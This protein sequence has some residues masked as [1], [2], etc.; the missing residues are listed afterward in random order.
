MIRT[1]RASAAKAP[2]ASLTS[3]GRRTQRSPSAPPCQPSTESAAHTVPGRVD[4]RRRRAGRRPARPAR[5]PPRRPGHA[6]RVPQRVDRRL[7][8]EREPL[9]ARRWAR[10]GRP[11]KRVD[12]FR[13]V[14]MTRALPVGSNR[15]MAWRISGGGSAS[16]GCRRGWPRGDAA[17]GVRR[18]SMSPRRGGGGRLPTPS[19]PTTRTASAPR[20]ADQFGG[21]GEAGDRTTGEDD[22]A[23]RDERSEQLGVVGLPHRRTVATAPAP[24]TGIWRDA[25]SGPGAPSRTSRRGRPRP[26]RCHGREGSAVELKVEVEA[27]E[28]GFDPARLA[29]DRRPLRRYVDDGLL[30]GWT[31]CS[32]ATARSSWSRR[33]A[34]ATSRRARRSSSTRCSAS[35]R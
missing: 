5:R 27:A 29:A 10:N 30:P 32:P 2:T 1:W 13:N 12:S 20:A 24:A 28:V 14:P 23:P 17:G 22:A 26:L 33:T 19:V 11:R 31:S 9:R 18:P 3:P 35:T 25:A 16:T 15:S 7:V 4:R 21:A 6:D 8:V 34:S